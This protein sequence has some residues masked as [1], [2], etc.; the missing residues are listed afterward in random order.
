MFCQLGIE[1]TVKALKFELLVLT[2]TLSK[3]KILNLNF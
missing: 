2:R 3:T 1:M